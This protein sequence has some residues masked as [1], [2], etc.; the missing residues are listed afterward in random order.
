[1]AALLYALI[2]TMV[3][4]VFF[5]TTEKSI[6]AMQA[7]LTTAQTLASVK[8]NTAFWVF[9]AVSFVGIMGS[10]MGGK[11]LVYYISY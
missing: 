7:Q 11:A 3:M 2:A 8:A 10:T 6:A 4:S 1:M 9:C 5:T